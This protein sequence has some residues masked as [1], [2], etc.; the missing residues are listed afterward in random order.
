MA[1]D[2]TLRN[3][4]DRYPVGSTVR[5]YHPGT[6]ELPWRGTPLDS[7]VVDADGT[8]TFSGLTPATAYVAGD[9]NGGPP[10]HFRTQPVELADDLLNAEEAEAGQ[11]VAWN[12]AIAAVDWGDPPSLDITNPRWGAVRG[13]DATA[14]F[15][16]IATYIQ[17]SSRQGHKIVVPEGEFAIHRPQLGDSSGLLGQ[18]LVIEGA[19]HATRLAPLHADSQL[20][21]V[22]PSNSTGFG[23]AVRDLYFGYDRLDAAVDHAYTDPLLWIEGIQDLEVRHCFF[24]GLGTGTQLA[25][26][27]SYEGA[28]EQCGFY[29]NRFMVP[30]VVKDSATGAIQ[31]Q[32]DTLAF[33]RCFVKGTPGGIVNRIAQGVHGLLFEHYKTY[34][35]DD[36]VAISA[37]NDREKMAV[38]FVQGAC[39]AGSTVI[40][41]AAG[42]VLGGYGSTAGYDTADR[43]YAGE[44]CFL[45][46]G[47]YAEVNKITAIDTVADTLTLAWPTQFDHGAA[48]TADAMAAQVLSGG[49]GLSLPSNS[50]I[51][52]MRDCHIEGNGVSIVAGNTRSLLIDGM[53]HT[54]RALIRTCNTLEDCELRRIEAWGAYQYP[55]ASAGM[56]Y[57][58]DVPPE[59]DPTR[60]PQRPVLGWPFRKG[61]GVGD[62]S[63]TLLRDPAGLMRTVGW[64]ERTELVNGTP[65]HTR[66]SHAVSTEVIEQIAVDELPRWW[67]RADGI[68]LW[69]DRSGWSVGSGSNGQAANA[70]SGGILRLTSEFGDTTL[71]AALPSSG[72]VSVLAAS[73]GTLVTITYTG[74]SG[75]TLTGCTAGVATTLTTGD[76]VSNNNAG[77]LAGDSAGS[78]QLQR[79]GNPTNLSKP[80]LWTPGYFGAGRLVGRGASGL[81]ALSIEGT[82]AVAL[83][84]QIRFLNGNSQ[85]FRV[86]QN[87][88]ALQIALADLIIASAGKGLKIKEGAAAMLGTGALIN[89]VANVVNANVT[90]TSRVFVQI[91]A[92][93][94]VAAPKPTVVTAN[95]G[96]FDVVT[97]V[98][99][100]NSSFTYLIVQPA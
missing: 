58:I 47:R 32:E 42:Q 52:T 85:E 18:R 56:N 69:D 62:P 5:L 17:S 4:A 88:L 99:G 86:E 83:G 3:L 40:S 96:S 93:S 84:P 20:R 100:D 79:Q 80:M 13:E 43:F 34:V 82:D 28:V 9:G 55:L 92:L 94:G 12:G 6:I 14:A 7:Q 23:L 63:V 49:V 73:S 22:A 53:E 39:P 24:R 8:V 60:K 35:A 48:S 64:L 45:G 36:H 59:L 78:V 70:L 89:G 68:Q 50:Q 21:I 95:A 19:G 38:G 11:Q 87:G 15:D 57:L 41:L 31:G 98:A 75:A 74:K 67:Q 46:Y 65:R 66:T 44:P 27:S 30:F 97:G 90:V 26:V 16:D 10:I 71:P 33:K 1:Q 72:T 81:P 76:R 77:G 2:H 51:V 61:F 25:L 91:T 54:T 37:T 29:V